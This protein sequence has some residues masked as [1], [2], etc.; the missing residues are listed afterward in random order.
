MSSYTLE[1]FI[2]DDQF[3]LP[4]NY[5]KGSDL[6]PVFLFTLLVPHS[7]SSSANLNHVVT[8]VI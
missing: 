1:L 4:V 6:T 3:L 2:C 5:H 8:F 7:S